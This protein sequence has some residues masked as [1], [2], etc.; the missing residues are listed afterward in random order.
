[1]GVGGGFGIVAARSF[2]TGNET[3]LK[4]SAAGVIVLGGILV[5]FIST[6]GSLFMMPILKL[7]NTPI[8]IILDITSLSRQNIWNNIKRLLEFLYR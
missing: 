5:I 1:M 6:I 7:L 4:R 2:G 3:L 8:N